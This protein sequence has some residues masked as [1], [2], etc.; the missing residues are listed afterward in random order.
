[1]ASTLPAFPPFDMETEKTTIGTRWTKWLLKLE[2]FMAAYA[3]TNVDR[4][5]AVLLHF[6]GDSVFELASTLDLTPLP[7]DQAANRPAE[8]VYESL[9]RVLTAHLCP[10]NNK[11]STCTHSGKPNKQK[12][13][14]L[15]NFLLD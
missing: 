11:E 13:S 1:M 3:I 14:L 10:T 4:Q 9:K 7:A 5:K 12:M 15:I 2:N 6:A 8:N